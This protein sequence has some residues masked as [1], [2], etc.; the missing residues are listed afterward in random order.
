MTLADVY[1]IERVA[2]SVAVQSP[3]TGPVYELALRRA[4]VEGVSFYPHEW[5]TATCMFKWQSYIYRAAYDRLIADY[6][7]RGIT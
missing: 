5:C 1:E 2:R 7:L 4:A 3:P 6:V